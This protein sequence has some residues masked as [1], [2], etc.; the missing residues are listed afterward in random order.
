MAENGVEVLVLRDAEG[1]VYALPRRMVER[2]RVPDELK[3]ALPLVQRS[4]SASWPSTL[5]SPAPTGAGRPPAFLTRVTDPQLPW[6]IGWLR[7]P[8]A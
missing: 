6:P 3:E 5:T 8:G 2:A 4:G 7:L 1:N